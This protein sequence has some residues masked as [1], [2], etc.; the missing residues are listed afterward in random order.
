MQN[1]M[2][3][4]Q[5]REILTGQQVKKLQEALLSW[6]A[7]NQRNLPWRQATDPYPVWVSEV[8]L[9]QTQVQTV[10]PYY[11][12]FLETFSNITTLADADTPQLLRLWAG[13][14]YYSRARNLQKAA[15]LIVERFAGRFPESYADML[16]LPGVG[17]YTAAA[18]ASIAFDQRYAVVDGNV[19]RVLAR[20]FAI[21]GDRKSGKVQRRFWEV[22]QCLLPERQPGDF[23]QAIMELGATICLPRNPQCHAC[24]WRPDCLAA[25]A[26]VQELLPEKSERPQTRKVQRVAVAVRHRGRYFL[27]RRAG[28]RL[29]EDFWEFPV[30]GRSATQKPTEQLTR[31]VAKEYGLK[32][33]DMER[34]MTIK[35]SITSHRITM[36]VF[37][38]RLEGRLNFEGN[39][40]QCRWVAVS[41][42]D[43]YPFASASRQILKRLEGENGQ[44]QRNSTTP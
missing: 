7:A 25:A 10:I 33:R 13:L 2:R 17:R 28:Q 4:L 37:H 19:T 3:K 31:Y 29:L 6:Y 5:A 8:M 39:N 35:H 22:A 20:L 43:R 24:P 21:W 23:N 40:R 9:Q 18:I 34:L 30:T 15:K 42:A 11:V 27:V 12:R 16:S 26:G 41:E 44:M 14:G 32:I 1:R 38:A 36:E